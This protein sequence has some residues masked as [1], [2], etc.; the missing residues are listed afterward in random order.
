MPNHCAL[1]QNLLLLTIPGAAEVEGR[2][3]CAVPDDEEEGLAAADSDDGGK[4]TS[5]RISAM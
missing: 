1:L 5:S 2:D 3:C 4:L